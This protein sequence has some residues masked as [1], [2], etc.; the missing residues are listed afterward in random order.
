VGLQEGG[1]VKIRPVLPRLYPAANVPMSG[2]Q[3][4]ARRF[5]Q[6]FAGGRPNRQRACR[7]SLPLRHSDRR[8]SRGHVPTVAGG[9]VATGAPGLEHSAGS[10]STSGRESACRRRCSYHR[11]RFGRRSAA[12]S[13]LREPGGHRSEASEKSR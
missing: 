1:A 7:M 10:V 13:Q 9:C 3:W 2:R 8:F 11:R 5:L 4:L 12:Y 6:L